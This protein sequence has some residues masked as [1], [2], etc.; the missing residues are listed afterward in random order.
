LA[1]P[2]LGMSPSVGVG[3][4]GGSGTPLAGDAKAN[5]VLMQQHQQRQMA[6]YLQAQAMQQQM[7]NAF[8]YGMV[9]QQY[10]FNPHQ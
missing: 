6:E 2:S 9:A 4:S 10:A 5:A 7:Q 3:D 8:A 1:D